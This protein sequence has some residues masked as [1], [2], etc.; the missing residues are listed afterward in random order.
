MSTLSQYIGDTD[1]IERFL[2]RQPGELSAFKRPFQLRTEFDLASTRLRFNSSKWASWQ[3]VNEGMNSYQT[4]FYLGS[5]WK[6]YTNVD[7]QRMLPGVDPS[8][9][10]LFLLPWRTVY[11]IASWYAPLATTPLVVVEW[12][13][14]RNYNSRFSKCKCRLTWEPRIQGRYTCSK[15]DVPSRL[16]F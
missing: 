2:V 14:N 15:S 6:G 12:K 11:T 8:A 13:P 9:W 1:I 16:P 3:Y 4:T 10:M 5:V 7:N